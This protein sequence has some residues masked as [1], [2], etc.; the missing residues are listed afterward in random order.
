MNLTGTH[1]F[2]ALAYIESLPVPSRGFDVA[3]SLLLAPLPRWPK[4]LTHLRLAH[5][6][7]PEFEVATAIEGILRGLE[8]AA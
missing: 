2:R 6:E 1:L 3:R 7:G 4:L 8:V 5:G